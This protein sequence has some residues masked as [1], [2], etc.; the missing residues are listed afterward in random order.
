MGLGKTNKRKGSNA[1]RLY[2]IK[3]R[4]MGFSFCE[5]SRFVSKKHDNA[6]I[7]LMYI[8]FNIQI[9]AG[10]QKNMNAGKELFFMKTCIDTMFPL[11]DEV[12]KKP[13]L[14]I[15]YEE[16]GRGH[17]RLPEHERVY[18]SMIQFDI[19][20]SMSPDLEHNGLKSFKFDLQSE[21]KHIVN[22]TF[23]DFKEKIILKHYKQN[24]PNNNT[25]E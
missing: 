25:S 23:A 6:K 24:E 20:K 18:M 7:D 16:V 21:F 11:G 17:K 15:H 22:V 13:L 1:E 9:K 12:F 5:T 14:L 10:K 8:P 19:F 4:E 3:F 2:A